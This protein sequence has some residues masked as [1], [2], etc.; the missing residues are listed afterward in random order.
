MKIVVYAIAKDEQVHVKRFCT[1]AADADMIVVADT[2]STDDTVKLLEAE[3]VFVHHI[4][5]KPW[6]FDDARN[7]CLALLPTDID[8]C[9]SLDLDEVL[10]PGWR[11]EIERVWVPG[12]T[13]R[14][15]YGFD[16]GR[17]I[18]FPYEKIHARHG[19]R[20]WL[21]CHERVIADCTTEVWADTDKLLVV[22]LPDPEKSRG[23]YLD[24]LRRSIEEQPTE[25]RNAFYYARE[26]S[27]YG[28]WPKAI[29]EAK[30]YLALK[31]ADWPNERCY[32]KRIVGKAHQEMGQLTEALQWLREAANEAPGTREPWYELALAC[33][34][35]H[36]WPESLGAALTCLA[37]TE[38][39]KVYTVDPIVWGS[40]PHD[41]AAIAAWNLGLYD[42]ALKHAKIAVDLSPD[43][44]RLRQ[45]LEWCEKSVKE[46]A[47]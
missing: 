46:R 7:A 25:A 31:G 9:V 38:R 22:H 5:I 15:H 30:R 8:V 36:R 14:M 39:E 28:D 37:I 10:Q 34:H 40:A 18:V 13:N 23:Q 41:Y 29:E 2:G 33:Y 4:S 26:L 21:P 16:W 17:G 47:A 32:A 12:W 45:N 27:F 11:E 42:L 44:L 43:D 35:A 19:F 20:W 3:G 6:R 1:A 24:I